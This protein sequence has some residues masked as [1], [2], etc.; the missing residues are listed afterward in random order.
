[1]NADGARMK[2]F[3]LQTLKDQAEYCNRFMRLNPALELMALKQALCEQYSDTSGAYV[4][5]DKI[6]GMT[7]LPSESI[8]NFAERIFSLLDEA[9]VGENLNNPL[10]ESVL[11]EVLVEGILNYAVS[12]KLIRDR[13]DNL[14][15]TLR[16]AVREQ[17][18]Q[19]SFD[20]RR[21]VKRP[22]EPMEVNAIKSDKTI[23]LR[24]Q[25]LK[26]D[27]DSNR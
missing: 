19:R 22:E 16:I 20:A 18:D 15:T 8:Q 26:W 12:R 2:S 27:S 9:F 17:T 5:K 24:T 10:F 7:Q 1:M 6:K 3:A 11:V 23:S 21:G 4:A 14:H 25:F 13:P